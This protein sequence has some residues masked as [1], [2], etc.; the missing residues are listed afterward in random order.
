MPNS[1][2]IFNKYYYS[3]KIGVRWAAHVSTQGEDENI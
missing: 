2:F 3:F 1:D